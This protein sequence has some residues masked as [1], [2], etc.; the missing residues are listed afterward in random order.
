MGIKTDTQAF[1]KWHIY[2]LIFPIP[3]P[4]IPMHALLGDMV[5]VTKS[6]GTAA[7]A[8]GGNTLAVR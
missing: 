4:S 8:P 6:Y 7:S 2:N 5:F 1:R 3:I